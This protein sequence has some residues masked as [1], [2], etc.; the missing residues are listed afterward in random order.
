VTI[1]AKWSETEKRRDKYF[2]SK[3]SAERFIAETIKEREEFG[4]QAVSVEERRWLGYWKERVGPLAMMPEV[5]HFWKMSGEQLQSIL[6]IEAA[7]QYTE[8]AKEEYDNKR[9]LGDVVSRVRAFGLHFGPI[10]LHE[11]VASDLEEYLGAFDGWTRWSHDKRLRPFYKFARRRRWV[12]TDVMG[13][14]PIPKTPS[15]EREIYTVE[16]FK[17][18]LTTA[19]DE[20]V[21]FLALSGF[22][23]LRTAELVRQFASEQVLQWSDI[24]WNDRLIHVRPGVAKGTK[25]ES[26]ERFTP[27]NE[28]LIRWLEPFKKNSGDCVPFS[29]SKLTELWQSVKVPHIHNGL[30]H[31][32]ISYALAANPEAGVQLVSQWAGSSEAT[33][34]KHYRRL[35]KPEVGRAWFGIRRESTQDVDKQTILA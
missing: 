12:R 34:L 20:L 2:D 5:V 13:E 30:R 27:I 28:A 18:L 24:H 29:V 33:V 4:K 31:S 15:P 26:D 1:P 23:F 16:Q 11:I 21:P 32:A 8:A 22:C 25:R 14:M 17:N 10:P 6:A 9:T 19:P 7:K 3:A 35:L